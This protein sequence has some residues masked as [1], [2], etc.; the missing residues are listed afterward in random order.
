LKVYNPEECRTWSIK[1]PH[2]LMN[3]FRYKSE[4]E[5]KKN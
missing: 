1:N 4:R 2:Y 3:T 5:R